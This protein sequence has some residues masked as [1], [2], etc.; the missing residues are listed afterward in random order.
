[1]KNKI[2]HSGEEILFAYHT[3]YWKRWGLQKP[4]GRKPK[5]QTP[6]VAGSGGMAEQAPEMQSAAHIP[7]G[8]TSEGQTQSEAMGVRVVI[9]HGSR[10]QGPDGGRARGRPRK[11]GIVLEHKNKTRSRIN[12]QYRWSTIG[13]DRYNLAQ[14]QV[15]R[16]AHGSLA[17]SSQQYDNS[18]GPVRSDNCGGSNE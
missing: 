17:D 11:T 14:L 18:E 5:A 6:Q 15:R 3:D 1:M 4:R 13:R 12:K 16:S 10:C 8:D 7:R 9:E 2:I